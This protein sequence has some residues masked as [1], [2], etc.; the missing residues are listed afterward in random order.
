MNLS[1][2]LW[3]AFITLLV[4][5]GPVE[6]AAVFASLTAGVHKTQRT[7]LAVRSVLIAGTMLV[8]FAV[9]GNLVLGLLHVS[10][11]SFQIAGGILLF[12]L[13]LTLTFASPGLSSLSEGE[14]R[15]A[16]R[17]G[18]IA[19]LPLAFPMI[20]GPGSLSAIVLLMSRLNTWPDDIAVLAILGVCLVLTFAAMLMAE[21][22]QHLLGE[23][24]SD[25]VGRISGVL[26][27]ALAVQFVLDGLA[28][29]AI[30]A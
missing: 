14:H 24:G 25:V 8:L 27:A 22:L 4:T 10:L 1:L 13:A 11:P 26:L 20:A 5:I 17:P 7:A 3:S 19:V 23:T 15:E 16:E 2:S 6:T 12:L 29:T 21:R 30:F 18:D 28:Q 9:G